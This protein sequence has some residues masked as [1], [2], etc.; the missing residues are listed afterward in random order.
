MS[1]RT[2]SVL[3]GMIVA[4]LIVALYC[5]LSYLGAFYP[6][7][8]P[9]TLLPRFLRIMFP[10]YAMIGGFAGWLCT[11]LSRAE[12]LRLAADG[13]VYSL[14]FLTLLCAW[15]R[16]FGSPPDEETRFVKQISTTFGSFVF[17][18]IYVYWM[19][20]KQKTNDR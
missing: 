20:R 7:P 3:Q 10:F 14:I 1:N 17:Y 6:Q 2:L 5:A 13:L 15:Q 4:P 12:R 9:L 11:K 16:I 18:F 19:K 8:F